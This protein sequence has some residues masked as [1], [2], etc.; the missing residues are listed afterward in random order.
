[1]SEASDPPPSLM[2]MR[3]K[4]RMRRCLLQAGNIFGSD[5]SAQSI[6]VGQQLRRLRQER[7]LTLR[8]L[9]E[10]SGLNVNTLSM[11]ENAKTSPSVATLQQLALALEVPV[12]AFFEMN[13]TKKNVVF[14]SASQRRRVEFNGG[15]LEDLG[16]GLKDQGVQ[17]FLI[18][19]KPNA[20]EP[21]DPVVHTGLEFV[22]C[23]EGCL[24]YNIAGECYLLSPGDSL[25]FEAH[26]PHYWQ[27]TGSIPSRS[28][29]VI[30][31]SDDKDQPGERHFSFASVD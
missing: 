12:T 20:D 11:I 15:G 30:C 18:Q 31:P 2:P 13:S 1:M 3:R 22:Y 17:P 14:C 28:L 23:L 4:R 6:D 10:K 21:P 25:I 19:L 5:E 7:E 24:T 16:S 29:L 8:A 27:N 26:M 9:A